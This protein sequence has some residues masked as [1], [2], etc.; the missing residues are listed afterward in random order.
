LTSSSDAAAF[1]ALD[2]PNPSINFFR[3]A[4]DVCVTSAIFIAFFRQLA[5]MLLAATQTQNY[6]VII[7]T[8]ES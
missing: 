1:P 4:F 3:H 8:K 2:H 6:A 7:Q 5:I